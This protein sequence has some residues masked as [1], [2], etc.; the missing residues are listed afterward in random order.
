MFKNRGIGAMY[1]IQFFVVIAVLVGYMGYYWI[2]RE[3]VS[4]E[5]ESLDISSNYVAARKEMIRREIDRTLNFIAY[6]RKTTESRIRQDI[7]ARIYDAHALASQIVER[8]KDKLTRKQ[9]EDMV[10]ETLR[11]IRFN[12]GRGYYF[13]TGLDGVEQLFADR[14]EMEGAPILDMKD[15][16]GKWI[17]RDMIHIVKSQDEGFIEY[18]WTKPESAGREFPKLA[19]VK[20]F[21]P[22]NWLIGTGEYLDDMDAELREE[23]LD[24]I[25]SLRV[26]NDGYVFVINYDGDVLCNF[27]HSPFG[28]KNLNEAGSPIA[29]EVFQKL[30]L[31]SHAPEGGFIR[32]T[33]PKPST[34]ENAEKI[35]FVRAVPEW[36]WYIGTGAYID[37]IQ[38]VIADNR[39]SLQK[40][41]R[42]EATHALVALGIGLIATVLL[43]H[44]FSRRIQAQCGLLTR[45]FEGA[46]REDITIDPSA[47]SIREFRVLA[48]AA[49]QMVAERKQL[50]E[51]ISRSEKME[52]LGRLAGGVAHDLNNVLTGLVSYP[53][54]ILTQID[55]SNPLWKPL[56]TM[57][58]SGETAAAIVE[59]LLTLARRSVATQKVINLNTLIKDYMASPEFMHRKRQYPQVTVQTDFTRN[60]LNIK[61]SP[62]HLSKMAMNLLVNAM[63]AMPDGG[64]LTVSTRITHLDQP[65]EGYDEVKEGDYVVLTVTDTGTGIPRND[66]KRI[67]EPFYTRKVMGRSG[68][69]LGLAIVWSTVSDHNGYVDVQSTVGQG[70][71]FMVYF[72]I[73]REEISAEIESTDLLALAGKGETILCVDDM[74][75]QRQLLQAML[76]RL[77]YHVETA[78]SGEAALEILRT[79]D[80]D[81]VIL[82]MIMD[83]GMDGLE[84]YRR[85]LRL[86]PGQKAIIASGFAENERVRK[87]QQLGAGAYLRKPY[88]LQALARAVREELARLPHLSEPS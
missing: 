10:R 62:I 40:R 19:F 23:T 70:A 33:W 69:G 22:F 52:S 32:Y 80:V 88:V 86:S 78:S 71:S 74:P 21:K 73:T 45:F 75:E 28:G 43:A 30:Q 14:P 54:F 50:E 9:L 68:T 66:L 15:T 36:R 63:E 59:D 20:L 1:L 55:E 84:T 17:I 77:N 51:R 67:F 46:A 16:Q 81:L 53:D 5:R 39:Q 2:S 87:A 38:Q 85:I 42:S 82:D 79:H 34:G 26:G 44:V 41:V 72:P 35:S 31:Y 83:P 27:P 64:T 61:G 11:P 3:Y 56:Q 76:S 12:K 57:K 8:N 4:F 49:N 24:R 6:K 37:E 60:M 13:A 25:R 7:R 65:L 58:K 18:T 47:M 29:R 48:R